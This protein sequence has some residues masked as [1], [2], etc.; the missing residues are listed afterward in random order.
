MP[1]TQA[2]IRNISDTACWA[3]L[4]RARETERPDALFKDP[5]AR[6][7]AGQRGEAIAATMPFS[8]KNSWSWM[9]RTYL[10]DHFITDQIRK[11]ADMVINLAAGLDARPYRMSLQ[12]SL[13]WIEIDLPEIL[14]YKEE[15]LRTEEPTCAL[16]RIPLDLADVSARRAI[17]DRLSQRV[18]NAL[19]IT[20][21]FII[22]LG[23][24]EVTA[25]AQ[26][27]AAAPSFKSWITDLASP[28][29]LALL[30]KH[31]NKQL[32][33]G[34]SPLKFGPPEGPDFFTPH[35]WKPMQVRSLLKTAASLKRLSFVMRLLSMLPAS[36]GA[37][38]KRPW[39]GVCLL[40]KRQDKI[41]A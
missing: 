4:Y 24:D 35:G 6:R 41:G 7:L 38:G 33:E 20:E 18:K 32:S 11:G 39:G 21:G 8:D 2:P 34:G 27:L 23:R 12:P 22:Y 17:F 15:I 40:Q 28:G 37:Q 30:Q 29:L 5:F 14:A 36:N 25:F 16:E 31:I 26:D 19:I 1:D 3:A 13:Q 9:A 10:F